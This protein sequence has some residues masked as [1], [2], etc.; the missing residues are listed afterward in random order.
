M[1]E[2]LKTFM[3]PKIRVYKKFLIIKILIFT[4]V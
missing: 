4:H 3:F 2:K 1:I